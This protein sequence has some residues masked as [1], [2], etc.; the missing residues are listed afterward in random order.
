MWKC[1]RA[2]EMMYYQEGG[3]HPGITLEW[4]GSLALVEWQ[5]L[6]SQ[7]V[8]IFHLWLLNM[9]EG[10]SFLASLV[11]ASSLAIYLGDSVVM[12]IKLNDT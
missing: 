1:Y 9:S 5:R 11:S 4:E 6:W 7:N 10:A 8:F 3:K 2:R 12:R